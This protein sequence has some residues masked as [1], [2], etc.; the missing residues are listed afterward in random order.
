MKSRSRSPIPERCPSVADLEFG[1]HLLHCVGLARLCA[2]QDEIARLAGQE[3]TDAIVSAVRAKMQTDQQHFESVAQ[4]LQAFA[5]AKP[6]AHSLRPN[7]LM[8]STRE[9]A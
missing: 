1:L 5:V 7:C 2:F 8:S 6:V 3:G 9:M 4:A